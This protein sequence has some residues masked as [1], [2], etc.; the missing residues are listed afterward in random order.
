MKL[1]VFFSVSPK[2]CIFNFFTSKLSENWSKSGLSFKLLTSPKKQRFSF[3]I[4][5]HF[6]SDCTLAQYKF[7]LSLLPDHI[8]IILRTSYK[9][10]FKEKTAVTRFLVTCCHDFLLF[11]TQQKSQKGSSHNYAIPNLLEILSMRSV[12]NF[13]LYFVHSGQRVHDNQIFFCIF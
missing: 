12:V 6:W 10:W 5:R 7:V 11:C 13:V 9:A 4:F 3:L 8:S 2:F 1:Y